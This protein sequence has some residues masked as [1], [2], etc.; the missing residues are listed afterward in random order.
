MADELGIAFDAVREVTV[1]ANE[2]FDTMTTIR[3][4]CDGTCAALG[5]AS[6]IPGAAAVTGPVI[7][8]YT[9]IR[10]T[11]STVIS[12]GGTICEFMNAVLEVMNEVDAALEGDFEQFAAE[13]L[14][15]AQKATTEA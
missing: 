3:D 13:A 5:A 12:V 10:P 15:L 14:E 2:I 6:A 8:T 9:S 1:T 7:S 11:L 4:I